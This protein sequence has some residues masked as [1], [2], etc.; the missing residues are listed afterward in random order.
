MDNRFREPANTALVLMLRGIKRK[1]KEPLAFFASDSVKGPE[2][3]LIIIKC[4][5]I[6]LECDMNLRGL[7][8]D[9]IF[10]Q[11]SEMFG[12]TKRKS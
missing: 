11:V 12:N 2:S 1:W 8:S 10:I 4:I 5:E 3:K 9:Q 7:T 6:I